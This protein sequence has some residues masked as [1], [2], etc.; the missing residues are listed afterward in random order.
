MDFPAV[1][2]KHFRVWASSKTDN[3][4]IAELDLL[5]PGGRPRSYPQ[6]NDWGAAICRDKE[7]FGDFRPLLLA[8]DQPL[9]PAR[10]V[11]LT[12]RM[13]PDG[14]LA[15]DAPV[16]EWLVLRMGCTTSGK[17]NHPAK[18]E[19]MGFEVDKLDSKLVQ[20]QAAMGLQKMSGGNA[21]AP[22]LKMFHLDS[23]E[24]GGQSWTENLAAEFERR[25]GYS[26]RPFLP[27]LGARLVTDADTTRRFLEDFRRTL[28]ALVAENFYGGMR[29]FA[30]SNGLAL[31]AESSA[32]AIP[33]HRPLD[34]FQYVDIPAGEA[35]ALGNFTSDGNI[36]GGLRDAVSAAHIL[37]KPMTPVEVFTCNRGDWNTSPRFLKAFG[38]KILA[39]GANE[40]TLHCY[41]HQP[42]GDLAPGWTMSH[43]GTT[44]NRHVTWW[45]DA[46]PW[47]ASISRSQVMLRQGR[48]VMD[49]CRLLADDESLAKYA[50]DRSTFWDAPAGYANDWITSGNLVS[51]FHVESGEIVAAGG[52][53]YRLLVLPERERMT[54]EVARKLHELVEAGGVVLGQRPTAR[55]GLR[56]G[57]TADKEFAQHVAALWGG[58]TESAQSRTVGKGRVLTGMTVDAALAALAVKPDVTWTTAD[59]VV[60]WHHRR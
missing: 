33:I 16:G 44:F 29:E 58:K 36:S 24:A 1:T 46:K 12:S 55:A 31:L 50:D 48:S 56:G 23:W 18:A 35:W 32:G 30:R 34:F 20:R 7:T 54:L 53:R 13:Q 37:G 60:R 9:N 25:N 4:W 6:F 43:Y 39:T 40:L 5:P 41:I 22:A 10:A 26:L 49:F 27:V 45:N 51:L 11:D 14:T 15:W 52:A 8:G 57:E 42:S 59:A 17:K 19:G 2:G 21:S 38:D 28:Q 47:L 3:F